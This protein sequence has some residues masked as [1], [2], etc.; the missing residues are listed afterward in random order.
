MYFDNIAFL[1]VVCISERMSMANQIQVGSKYFLDRMTIWI[2]SDGDS[3][4]IVYDDYGNRV[5][6]L[7]LSHF[8]TY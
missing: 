4:G 8:S 1:P 3:Y 2:D 7:K 5:G 6:Q